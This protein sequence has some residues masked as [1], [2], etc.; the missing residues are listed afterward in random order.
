MGL[1]NFYKKYRQVTEIINF[2]LI[3]NLTNVINQL[4]IKYLK[5]KF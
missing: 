5:F 4:I 1:F 2:N 3:R